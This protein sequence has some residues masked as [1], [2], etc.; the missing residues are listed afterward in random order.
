MGMLVI[1]KDYRVSLV[2][3]K[4]NRAMSTDKILEEDLDQSAFQ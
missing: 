4:Q 2:E 1:G 3:N